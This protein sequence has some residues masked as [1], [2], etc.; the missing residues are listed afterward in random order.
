MR[1]QIL[2]FFLLFILYILLNNT[3]I[4]IYIRNNLLKINCVGSELYLGIMAFI[5]VLLAFGLYNFMN[6]FKEEFHFEVS[7][8]RKKCLFQKDRLCPASGSSPY[9]CGVG[10]YGKPHGFKY[11]PDCQMGQKCPKGCPPK[12]ECKPN[13]NYTTLGDYKKLESV[14]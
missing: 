5:F 8:G 7:P 6:Y 11:T 13:I 10:F 4:Q 2:Y 12:K 14:Y 1:N 9:C 3:Y